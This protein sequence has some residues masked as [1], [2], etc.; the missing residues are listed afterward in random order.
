MQKGHVVVRGIVGSIPDAQAIAAALAETPCM[1]DVEDQEHD[2]GGRQ[3]PAE[4]RPGVRL[5]VPGGREGRPKKKGDASA[6]RER[7][8]AARE[9]S[10]WPVPSCR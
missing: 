7:V 6:G 9:G 10:R 4:V 5:E 2:A 1:S 8:R 3:R